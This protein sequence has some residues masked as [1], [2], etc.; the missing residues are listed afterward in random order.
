M[1]LLFYALLRFAENRSFH[2]HV[3]QRVFHF[4][5]ADPDPRDPASMVRPRW[6]LLTLGTLA[7]LVGVTRGQFGSEPPVDL[8]CGD[9]NCYEGK[10]IVAVLDYR[11]F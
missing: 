5:A 4:Q 6:F 2:C 11:L 10:N 7:G 3:P 8:Y 9:M 1:V